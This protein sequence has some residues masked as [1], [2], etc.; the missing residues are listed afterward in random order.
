MTPGSN[1]DA[2][3]LAS[4]RWYRENFT[5]ERGIHMSVKDSTARNDHDKIACDS[6][7]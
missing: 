4:L 7:N 2:K 3:M 5:L 6:R 1:G